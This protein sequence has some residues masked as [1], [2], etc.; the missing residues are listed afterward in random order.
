MTDATNRFG[1]WPWPARIAL[2][3]FS[4]LLAFTVLSAFLD[5]GTTPDDNESGSGS[6]RSTSAKG[7]AAYAE[8]LDRFDIDVDRSGDLPDFAKNR[9]VVVSDVAALSD[10]ERFQL[11]Q[12]AE[13][14]DRVVM[15]GEP[16]AGINAPA[17]EPEG[18][19]VVSAAPTFPGQRISSEGDG[20]FSDLGGTELLA[21]DSDAAVVAATS[22]G[23]GAYVFV[24]TTSIF[25]NSYLDSAANAALG[26][27][28]VDEGPVLFIDRMRRRGTGWNAI[29]EQFRVAVYGLLIAL[30]LYGWSRGKRFGPVEAA[31]RTFDPPRIAYVDAL[32]HSLAR[33]GASPPSPPARST[34]TKEQT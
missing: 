9:T 7:W 19:I 29:P 2:V 26:I 33:T 15:V 34:V 28:I 21:G 5:A 31:D 12:L 25:D 20:S 8:L 4:A 32:A 27:E 30:G 24:A 16:M 22:A 10:A 3:A 1:S 23:R 18:P 14:G 11:R 17:W 13:Q 6:T